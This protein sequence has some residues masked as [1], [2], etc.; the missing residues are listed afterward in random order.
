MPFYMSSE[1]DEWI[2]C[3]D[4]VWYRMFGGGISFPARALD[5]AKRSSPAQQLASGSSSPE[6]E[7]QAGTPT[8]TGT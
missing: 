1:S 6:S 8:T 5:P 4:A 3:S 7:P 2:E